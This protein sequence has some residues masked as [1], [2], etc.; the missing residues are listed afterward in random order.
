MVRKTK[1]LSFQFGEQFHLILLDN[2]T[3]NEVEVVTIEVGEENKEE[4]FSYF[5]A[6]GTKIFQKAVMMGIEIKIGSMLETNLLGLK[7]IYHK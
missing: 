3:L 1:G 2:E 7:S 6:S 5:P 4:A